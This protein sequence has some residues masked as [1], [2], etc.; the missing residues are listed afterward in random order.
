M[1]EV[2][3]ISHL[4][5]AFG[6]TEALKSISF[7]IARGEARALLGENGA[8]KST[9]V[10][11]LNGLVRPDSG[12]IR[13]NGR[14]YRPAGLSDAQKAGVSTAF[15]ELSLLPELSVAINLA[16]PDLPT[17]G[18]NLVRFEE[19]KRRAAATLASFN[20]FDIDPAS[21]VSSLTLSD[22]QR[23]E[24]I[25]A[26]SRTPTLLI[27]DEPTAALT[28]VGWL[29]ERIRALK[30]EGRAVLFITHRLKEARDL[31]ERATVLRNGEVAGTMDLANASDNELFRLMIGRSMGTAFP[32]RPNRTAPA[33]KDK[34]EEIVLSVE[35]L[36]S[37]AFGPATFSVRRGE[38]VG[39]AALE[40]QGQRALFNALAGIDRITAGEVRIYGKHVKLRSPVVAK[41]HGI[42]FVPE[43]RKEEGLFFGLLTRANV[44]IS[45]I[46]R[47]GRFGLVGRKAEIGGISGVSEAVDLPARYHDLPVDALSGGNQQKALIARA[48]F[49]RAKCLLMFDPTRGVDVG[50]KQAIYSVIREAASEGTGI[51][52]YS[53][54]LR[55]ITA[56]SDRCVVIYG[57]RIVG[58]C[59]SESLKEEELLKKMHNAHVDGAKEDLQGGREQRAKSL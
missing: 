35:G 12:T 20:I 44:S 14:E 8:G 50:T 57:N 39:V 6:A 1:D 41:K 27:L 33:T 43:E 11:I 26:L 21:L 9:C 48:L 46:A 38:V 34:E 45:N 15:Q 10:R 59:R 4:A 18:F 56:L 19:V 54:E 7:D 29:Y 49:G 37:G 22:K 40:G 47:V 52:L 30:A 13:L 28:D 16:M 42:S 17:N 51:L 58:E 3:H 31:C 36:R 55:E 32:D 2:L 24:I 53:T 25:R 23:L 5:K